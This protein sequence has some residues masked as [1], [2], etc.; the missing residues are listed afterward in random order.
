[1][2]KIRDIM[3]PAPPGTTPADSLAAAAKVMRDEGISSVLVLDRGKLRG[4]V[5]DRDIILRA[6]AEDRDPRTTPVSDICT[7]DLAVL[8]PDDDVTEA[9]RII[10]E[11][12]ENR[13]PVVEDGHLVGVLSLADLALWLGEWSSKRDAGVPGGCTTVRSCE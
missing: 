1:M 3:S 4:M 5:T 2:N 13:V 11:H 6:V 10:H 9:T 7:Q 12:A 8:S